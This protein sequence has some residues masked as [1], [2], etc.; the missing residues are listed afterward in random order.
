[1]SKYVCFLA[2]L[3]TSFFSPVFSEN[4][5]RNALQDTGMQSFHA[6]VQNSANQNG[7]QSGSQSG[8][9]STYQAQAAR[10]PF[11]AFTGKI[12]K[13]KV[14]MRL[15]PSLD[16]TIIR[17]LNADETVMILGETEEFYAVEPPSELKAYIFRTYVLDGIIEGNHV[18]VRL[19]PDL[20]S[21]VIAQLN[22]GDTV[23]GA[24]SGLDKKWLE[25]AL[26]AT[27]RFYVAKDYIEKIGDASL[28]AN[29]KRRREE[30]AAILNMARLNSQ[31]ELQKPFD[32]IQLE[33]INQ[34]LNLVATK[35]S[36][37]PAES[38]KAKELLTSIQNSYLNKK[39]AYMESQHHQQ[40][41]S[42]QKEERAAIPEFSNQKPKTALVNS[43][44]ASWIPLEQSIYEEWK[45]QNGNMSIEEYYTQSAQGALE[46]HGVIEPYNRTVKN[47]P[48]DY[49]LTSQ[50]THLPIAYL[51][52][53]QA[54]LQD[55]SGEEVTIRVLPRNNQNF[56]YP[57]YFVLSIE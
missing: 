18:N 47:K 5:E 30:A 51:Y 12:L 40:Q 56:A 46:L 17:E 27:T 35:Y 33:G 1:M 49:V 57:A 26:P 24:V 10:S 2:L 34:K 11:T 14:R 13:N 50:T 15:Q 31:I 36:D 48:G 28:M 53:T 23:K 9:R 6:Q 41:H 3:S 42:Q 44:M 55:R 21:P 29:L 25:I 37:F 4:E 43:K 8:S 32:Q 22:S 16:G 19:E 54:N 20:S 7:P 38:A 52:S 45:I 39:I